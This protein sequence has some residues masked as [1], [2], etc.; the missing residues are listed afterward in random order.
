[1]LHCSAVR[2]RVNSGM[3][4]DNIY[5]TTC[6]FRGGGRRQV[7][8]GESQIKASI[9]SPHRHPALPGTRYIRDRK[10]TM[11]QWVHEV[12]FDLPL[13]EDHR[14]PNQTGRG[15]P[16]H[17]YI[18]I[19]STT[20]TLHPASCVVHSMWMMAAELLMDSDGILWPSGQ[21]TLQYIPCMKNSCTALCSSCRID[22]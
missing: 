18:H 6:V 14:S 15:L 12:V 20:Y 2:N 5:D 11:S 4:Y 1:M 8:C 19:S 7:R 22:V 16:A 13:K 10:E 17:F 21:A 3:P 9:I